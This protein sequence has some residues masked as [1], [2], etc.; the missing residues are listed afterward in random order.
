MWDLIVSVP[1]HCL[2]FYF[3]FVQEANDVCQMSRCSIWIT[4]KVRI[5]CVASVEEAR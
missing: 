3:V 2:S 5:F 4:S 1:D